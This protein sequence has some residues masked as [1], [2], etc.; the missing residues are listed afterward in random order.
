M[1]DE[2]Q[3]W[4]RQPMVWLFLGVLALSL[5]GCAAMLWLAVTSN[6]GLVADDYYK[7]GQ[8]IG[9]EIKRD[10]AARQLG[11]SAQLMLGEDG[12]ALRVQM[13]G[14]EAPATLK[15]R[16]VHPTR[17]GLDRQV[18]LRQ[19]ASGLYVGRLDAT[20]ATQRWLLQIEDPADRWRLRGE[21]QLGPG[22][23]VTLKPQ[24]A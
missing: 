4:Q 2:S 1:Q 24:P 23:A 7:R 5:V 14:A 19:D 13:P 11:L 21:A 8:E 16:L 3:G 20:L 17:A 22:Q 18:E 6:D 9:M 12:Q 10:D 15:L